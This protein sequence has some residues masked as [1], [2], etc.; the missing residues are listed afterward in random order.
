MSDLRSNTKVKFVHGNRDAF[1][2]TL[3]KRAQDYFVQK[4]ILRTGTRLLRLKCAFWLLVFIGSYGLILSNHFNVGADILL[5]I[6]F[7][8]SMLAIAINAGH[9][10][11]HR[12]FS[13][14]P[15][16][17]TLIAHS[18]DLMG[19]NSRV[20]DILHNKTHHPYVNIPGNDEDIDTGPFL[21]LSPATEY[22]SIY[23][24]QHI[25]CLFLYSMF[26]LFWVFFKDFKFFGKRKIGPAYYRVPAFKEFALLIIAKLFYFSYTILVPMLFLPNPWWQI[27]VGF[28]IFHMTMGI[29][30]GLT[31]LTTHYVMETEHMSTK[32]P[33]EIDCHWAC[34]VLR[35]TTDFA[36]QS[37]TYNWCFGGLNTH[38]AHHLFPN[39]S[40]IHHPDLSR[41][42]RQTAQEFGYPYFEHTGIRSAF[43]SHLRFLKKM[44]RPV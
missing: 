14:Y 21:R 36:T 9:E 29:T 8:F 15:A 38:V 33:A 42:I 43:R 16:I 40:H 20:W 24:F 18:I 32:Q 5:T 27:I 34:H 23:R 12:A 1:F 26:T 7:G 37:K 4:G 6:I 19:F 2:D 28:F 31:F 39:I 3:R 41:I 11:S 10:A 13:A 17:N 44:G 30:F 35:S 22:R 25:Y